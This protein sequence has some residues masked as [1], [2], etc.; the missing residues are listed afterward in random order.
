MS[1]STLYLIALL[2]AT[3]WSGAALLEKEGKGLSRDCGG[4]G[5]RDLRT[6]RSDLVNAQ[7]AKSHPDSEG[8]CVESLFAR[9]NLV[10]WCIVPFDASKRGPEERAAMLEKLGITQFAYDYR[11][12]HIPSFDAE[13]E[14]L[15]HHHIRLLAWWF[16]TTLND[17][18]R[19]ILAVLEKHHLHGVQLWVMGGGEP[20]TTPA[21]QAQ[22]VKDEVSRIRPI[23]Q[24]AL[25]IGSQVG[26][27]NH[28]GWFGEPENQL[29]I[30][31][32][33]RAEAIAN[34]GIVY[35]LHHG[36]S[37]IDRF[38]GLLQKMKPHLLAININGM[39]RDGD[40]NGKLI[41]PLGQGDLEV[42]L[43]RTICESGWR[44]PIGLL[45][46]TDKDAQDRLLDNL[47]G[48]DWINGQLQGHA[49]LKPEPRSWP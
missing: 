11:A 35:N 43:L 31:E 13:V 5:E 12:E 30:I 47:D 33:F 27:Y 6:R 26:L 3:V 32:A 4:E 23:A 49:R 2:A 21:E 36:H 22:R 41:L 1:R 16:P 24:A 15:Q 17:E 44:G 38:A 8:S 37:H 40:K 34:I 28:D 25:K 46:H 9:T 39:V 45:N 29:A 19:G 14:A 20:T 10:A 7:T 18:A 48:L 42:E